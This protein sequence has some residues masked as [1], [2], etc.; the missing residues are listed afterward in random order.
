MGRAVVLWIGD[1]HDLLVVPTFAVAKNHLRTRPRLLIA[2]LKL[3]EYNGLHLALRAR[4]DGI[5]A[6]VIGASDSVWQAEA[7]RLGAC[8]LPLDC[9][10]A[11]TLQ[12]LVSDLLP[13]INPV[14]GAPRFTQ[15]SRPSPDAFSVLTPDTLG[16]VH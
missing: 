2:E 15:I 1:K 14:H 13:E 10:G 8:Y 11:E 16:L 4:V 6:I 3:G 12:S 5:P 9:L 7:E